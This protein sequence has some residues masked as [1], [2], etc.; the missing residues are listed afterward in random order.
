MILLYLLFLITYLTFFVKISS[1]VLAVINIIIIKFL[2]VNLT[3]ILNTFF[4][5]FC[6]G[7]TIFA[8][9]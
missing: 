6:I 3:S 9:S 5:R 1:S 7:K 8:I 2:K 4:Y